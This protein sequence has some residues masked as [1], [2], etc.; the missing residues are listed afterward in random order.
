MDRRVDMSVKKWI[1]TAGVA[2]ATC[3][4]AVAVDIKLSDREQM[5][6]PT[7]VQASCDNGCASCSSVCDSACSLGGGAGGLF[8]CDSGCNAGCDSGCWDLA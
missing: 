6:A 1:L 8:G 3:G 5:I 4:Q 2:M 7:V